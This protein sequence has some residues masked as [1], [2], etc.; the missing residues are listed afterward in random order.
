[1]KSQREYFLKEQ[2]R[3]IKKE[4][5]EEDD[6]SK[7]V[8]ELQEKI[9]KARMPKKVREEAEKQLGRLSRMHPDS[10]EATVVRSYLEWLGG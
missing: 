5:G 7:E 3:A 6:I 9:R 8:E 4:L 2:M 10:A 1:D